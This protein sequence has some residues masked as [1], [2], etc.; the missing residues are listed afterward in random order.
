MWSRFA[1]CATPGWS[2]LAWTDN[3]A[4][5]H[6]TKLMRWV[7]LEQCPALAGCRR[8][9]DTELAAGRPVVGTRAGESPRQR[10][11]RLAHEHR[12]VGDAVAVAR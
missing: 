2:R 1:A 9:V 3:D 4:D 8:E 6:A 7:C 12:V 11:R 10:G 5:E